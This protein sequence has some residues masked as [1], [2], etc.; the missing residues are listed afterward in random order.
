[1]NSFDSSEARVFL[2]EFRF[3]YYIFGGDRSNQ[4]SPKKGISFALNEILLSHMISFEWLTYLTALSLEFQTACALEVF[5][6]VQSDACPSVHTGLLRTRILQKEIKKVF[7]N[8][9]VV[10]RKSHILSAS[11]KAMKPHGKGL[12][13]YA[14]QYLLLAIADR[15][16][17]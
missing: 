17:T 11:T 5:T 9:C 14:R 12:Y 1:M 4:F 8:A 2:V 15:K 10:T 16:L 7:H 3:T 13:D 6:R